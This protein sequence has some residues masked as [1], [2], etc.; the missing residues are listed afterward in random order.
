MLYHQVN[1]MQTTRSRF[2]IGDFMVEPLLNRITGP[3]GVSVVEPKVMHV[4]TF[5]ADHPGEVLTKDALIEEVWEG[6]VV[7]DYV[8]SRSISQLRKI[9]DDSYKAPRYIETVSKTGYRLIAEVYSRG[10]DS[11]P[12]YANRY[13]DSQPSSDQDIEIVPNIQ[14]P[15]I[16]PARKG[17]LNWQVLVLLTIVAAIIA[18]ASNQLIDDMP[19][20]SPLPASLF[21][22]TPGIEL[23]PKFSPDGSM[24]AFIRFNQDT[25]YDVYVKMVGTDSELQLTNSPE[26]DFYHSW[27]A[28]GKHITFQRIGQGGCGVYQIP[29]LGGIAKK[30]IDC[31][32]S[33]RDLHWAPDGSSFV[34]TQSDKDT[35]E[36]HLSLIDAN[37][38][39]KKSFTSPPSAYS[40]FAPA[41]SPD[42]THIA[43]ARGFYGEIEDLFVVPITGGEPRRLTFDNRDVSGFSWTPDSRSIVFS[44][45]RTGN[46]RL[47]EVDISDGD[48]TWVSDIATLDPG[49]PEIARDGKHLIYEEWVFELNIWELALQSNDTEAP[50]MTP[51]FTSTRSDFQP[52]YSPDGKH[53]LYVSNK[54]GSPQ[55]CI[56]NSDGTETSVLVSMD[57][58]FLQFPKW[59]PD[60]KHIVFNAFVDGHTHIFTVDARGGQPKQ[61]TTM[62]YEHRLSGWSRDGQW[63]YFASNRTG[64]WQLWKMNMHGSSEVQVT[65]DGGYMAMESTDGKTL[66]FSKL[67]TD[68]LW[69]LD[70][71]GHE[72]QVLTDLQRF[73]W[74]NWQ[75]ADA[76]IYYY[77][78]M[79][80]NVEL[81]FYSFD[82]GSTASVAN[83]PPFQVSPEPGM[84]I[85]PDGLRLLLTRT[86]RSE[87]DLMLVS[88][89]PARM[90]W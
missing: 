65:Q 20:R 58:A 27:T 59:S 38:H 78:R 11:A 57:D 19:P 24:V 8:V 56:G 70:K 77:R 44:S 68:G 84:A 34:I 45:N 3:E 10:Q 82:T 37:T 39:E 61:L 2:T 72:H 80:P 29:V 42:G 25:R 12:P 52:D 23:M 31:Q 14:A 63:I 87:S 4:L 73:D 40:D 53:V 47:W 18:W 1:I 41:F 54:S 85:S 88:I 21:T 16:E 35:P 28:D 7:T 36:S 83:I 48:I 55:I 6:T 75:V 17:I 22:S 15:A 89:D 50:Q 43:F 49:H 46:Y 66:Y 26:S 9:F 5:L 51:R 60:G 32:P 67:A 81:S 69:K 74:G 64:A 13:G 76:G 86:D 33:Q 79:Q 71:D 30:R 62:E 90:S